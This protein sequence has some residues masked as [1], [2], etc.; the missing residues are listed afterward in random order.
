MKDKIN[1]E[2]LNLQD[3]LQNLSNA[4]THI[5]K[6]EELSTNVISGVKQIQNSYEKHLNQ[7]SDLFKQSI[8]AYEQESDKKITELQTL[9]KKQVLEAQNVLQ[10]LK[11]KSDEIQKS[12]NDTLE[13]ASE[14]YDR[15]LDKNF[16]HTKHQMEQVS[17][18]YQKR[19]DE[20]T[21]ILAEFTRLTQKSEKVN[22]EHLAKNSQMYEQKVSTL[23]D[24][25]Q[26]NVEKMNALLSQYE[27]LGKATAV[28]YSKVNE[29]NFPTHLKNIGLRMDELN[30]NIAAYTTKLD[31]LETNFNKN[32]K[33]IANIKYLIILVLI[34]V[35]AMSL[36]IAMKY[37]P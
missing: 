3:E 5:R 14:Q 34:F 8:A 16:L 35:V 32:T 15:F 13:K 36:D 31:A 33:D 1:S 18:A 23:V 12:A 26:N 19:V 30:T 21:E 29:I 24:S 10:D 28:L 17:L 6:A 4:V 11:Q 7:L 9:A 27:E 22:Q 37:L 2:L 25:H 20:E